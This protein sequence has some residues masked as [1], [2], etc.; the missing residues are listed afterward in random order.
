MDDKI[1]SLEEKRVD[2]EYKETG[3]IKVNSPFTP[4]W[5]ENSTPSLWDRAKR[6]Y[7]KYAGVEEIPNDDNETPDVSE[8]TE[9]EQS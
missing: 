9:N 3:K 1:V 7:R 5:L 6:A 4:E 8:R 2:K